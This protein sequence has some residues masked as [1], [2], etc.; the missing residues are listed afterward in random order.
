MKR[1]LLLILLSLLLCLSAFSCKQKSTE[2]TDTTPGDTLTEPTITEPEEEPVAFPWSEEVPKTI[3]I[4]AI[5]NSFSVDA[6]EYLYQIARS[7]GV[8]E[9]ILGDL[10]VGGCTLEMHLDYAKRNVPEYRYYKNTT[11]TWVTTDGVTMLEG[12]K[13]EDW[14]II[15]LQQSSKIGGL[16]ETYD[17]FLTQLVDEVRRERT[18]PDAEIY[19]HMTWAFQH[20]C[21][22]PTFA[23]NYQRNQLK[24][25]SMIVNA[26]KEC[27]L[28]E[29]RIVGMIPNATALQNAR[30]SF[31][32]DNLTRDGYHMNYTLGRYIT[33]L[34]YF[35]A[36]TGVDPE[37]VPY[38]PSLDITPEVRAMAI[39]SVRDAMRYPYKVT[40]STHT[41]GTWDSTNK[42]YNK[43][44]NAADCYAMDAAL[45]LG[46]GIDLSG[47]TLMP[48]EYIA[49]GFYYC[50]NGTTVTR[51]DEGASA[52]QQNVCTK[53]IF[54]KSEIPEGSIIICDLG[55]QFRPEMWVSKS[56]KA[57]VRPPLISNSLTVLDATFWGENQ[58]IAWNICTSP[59]KE[60]IS[61]FYAAAASHVRVYI[62]NTK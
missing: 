24:M 59:E 11:G 25:Y 15:T 33:A 42:D 35:C 62:P 8:E 56:K 16:T 46:V 39:D 40:K 32:G 12:L 7:A 27:V 53:K 52:Y 17:L 21:T 61:G 9:I 31:V 23:S 41:E 13:D 36:I 43:V 5:G 49:N 22:Q 18:N 10:Y 4:L 58:F 45:A 50:P 37:R 30:T 57:E 44:V 47:Y 51:P 14:D 3:K 6:M 55:W 48:Y 29:T 2:S 26:Y 60:N 28:P 19:W 1:R 20:D 38:V 54:T 34:T